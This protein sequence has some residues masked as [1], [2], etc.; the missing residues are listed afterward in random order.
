MF[1][2]KA[3]DKFKT[4][5]LYSVTYLFRKSRRLWHNVDKYCTAE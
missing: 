3:I 2:T 5:H 4:H 1:Q